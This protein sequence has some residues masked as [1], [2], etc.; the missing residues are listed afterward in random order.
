MDIAFS[1]FFCLSSAMSHLDR[2]NWENCPQ[3]PNGIARD[4]A[5]KGLYHLYYSHARSFWVLPA[6]ATVLGQML[7][8]AGDGHGHTIRQLPFFGGGQFAEP[9]EVSHPVAR[10]LELAFEPSMFRAANR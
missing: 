2:E 5:E 8:Q 1:K 3:G 4:L 6:L 10:L 7:L 9:H